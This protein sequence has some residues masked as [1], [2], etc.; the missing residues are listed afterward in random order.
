MSEI[1]QIPKPTRGPWVARAH[2]DG[3]GTQWTIG[4]EEPGPH[5]TIARFFQSMDGA[6]NAE[7][8][9]RLA[10]AAPELLEALILHREYETLPADRGGPNGPKGQAHARW[11]AARDAAL[12]HIPIR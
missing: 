8:N 9:A 5:Y 1:N 6:R 4:S 3:R 11:I 10:A 12:S 2:L 7:A